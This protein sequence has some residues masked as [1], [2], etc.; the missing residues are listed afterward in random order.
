V[1]LAEAFGWESGG[2]VAAVCHG[3]A[4]IVDVT[5]SDGRPLV[6]VRRVAAFANAEERAAGLTSVVPFLLQDAPEEGGATHEG[7]ADFTAHVVVDGRLVTGQNPVPGA[8]TA[9]AAVEVL[10]NV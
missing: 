3:S 7:A 10:E 2:V 9:Q 8:G 1:T 5:L 4:G 6:A